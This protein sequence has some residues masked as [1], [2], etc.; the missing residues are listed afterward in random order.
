MKSSFLRPLLEVAVMLLVVLGAARWLTGLFAK[1]T[2]TY[3]VSA[4]RQLRLLFWP[5]LAL[6]AGL[7]VLPAVALSGPE[8]S[9]FEW[10]LTIGFLLFTLALSGP[11]LLLHLRYLTLNH[12]T[13]LVFQ[14]T[15]NRLEVYD[16]GQRVAF[17]RRD[18]AGVESVT[19][20][21]RRTFWGKYNY[22]CL[23]LV[24]GRSIV[25]TS[26]LTDLKP[27]AVFLRNAPTERRTRAW[28]WV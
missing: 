1:R 8:A 13:T 27:L 7:S 21:A 20:S 6:G 10:A 15:E 3:Q 17:A 9:Q 4:A 12:D 14:P 24:D 26:L 22:L 16:A 5:L 28:C 19:C 25:L 18:L 11:A 23:H 2:H